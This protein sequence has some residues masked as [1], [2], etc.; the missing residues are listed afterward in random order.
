MPRITNHRNNDQ[1]C[2][3]IIYH[4]VVDTVGVWRLQALA[5]SLNYSVTNIQSLRVASNNISNLPF[6]RLWSK[7]AS[8]HQRTS[9][10]CNNIW[11]WRPMFGR[12]SLL[13]GNSRAIKIA[14]FCCISQR[15]HQGLLSRESCW[16]W[17]KGACSCGKEMTD[18]KD[19]IS[20]PI[21]ETNFTGCF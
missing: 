16:V 1:V 15:R 10:Q 5:S 13:W 14:I 12:A 20:T 8:N 21:L 17:W 6:L 19:L 11:L 9:D 18:M 2:I 7:I 3:S 4:S